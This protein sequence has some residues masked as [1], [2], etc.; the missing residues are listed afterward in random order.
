M[1]IQVYVSNNK[2]SKDDVAVVDVVVV[3]LCY[4]QHPI[5]L[6]FPTRLH[7]SLNIKNNTTEYLLEL[8]TSIIATAPTIYF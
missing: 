2:K 7:A 1:V 6:T 4:L 8:C 3:M 5:F